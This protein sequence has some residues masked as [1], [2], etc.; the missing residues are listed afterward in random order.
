MKKYPITGT[1][2]SCGAIH[3]AGCTCSGHDKAGQVNRAQEMAGIHPDV[4]DGM[5]DPRLVLHSD[6]LFSSV[7]GS[8]ISRRDLLKAAGVAAL[9]GLLGSGPPSPPTRNSIR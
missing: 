4:A 2:D 1:T 3:I 7:L 5:P 8:G 6:P 9:S